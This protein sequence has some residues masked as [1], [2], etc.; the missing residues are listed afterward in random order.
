[1]ALTPQ[2]ELEL[3]ELEE[4]EYNDSLNQKPQG[5][6][7]K[8]WDA[9]KKPEELSRKGLGMITEAITPSMKKIESG[10]ASIPGIAA[11]AGMESLTEVAP[12]FV[13]RTSLLTA[14]GL[15]MVKAAKEPIKAAGK[16]VGNMAEEISGLTYKTPGV[17]KETFNDPSLI[18]AKGLD[19][20]RK[21]YR[22][23]KGLTPQI[24]DELKQIFDKSD[25]VQ[26][27]LQFARDGSLSADEALE[28][29]HI[30]KSI[31]K[32]ISPIAFDAAEDTLNAV[33]KQKFGGADTAF[34]RGIK[35]ENMRRWLPINKSGTPSLAKGVAMSVMPKLAY[36]AP[37][38]VQGLGAAGLGLSRKLVSPMINNPVKS[39][40]ALKLSDLLR[41]EQ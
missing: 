38:I 39:A 17:L 8:G 9:L 15:G 20:A 34:S 21:L 24:R 35:A 5:M 36:V 23:A 6:V 1:M 33:A 7:S 22:E 32:A 26:K 25:T 14:G 27:A 19:S 11:R 30:L 12:S 28:A 16:F 3:L 18:F 4:Q 40:I 13:D 31:K 10:K 41:K 2:Q 29:R 37:P